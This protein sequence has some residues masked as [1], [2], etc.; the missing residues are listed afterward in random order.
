MTGSRSRTSATS[1]YS[2]LMKLSVAELS[3][4]LADRG[5]DPDEL[6]NKQAMA[7][8]LVEL[9]TE[10]AQQESPE[11]QLGSAPSEGGEAAAEPGKQ[12]E[13][14][15]CPGMVGSRRCNKE[16]VPGD[17]VVVYYRFDEGEPSEEY[18]RENSYC[19]GC[20]HALLAAGKVVALRGVVCEP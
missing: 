2:R 13:P 15:R 5:C 12:S 10:E 1:P 7:K 14:L 3:G 4:M 8:R 20:A 17:W 19:S 11:A 16:L 9:L 6:P 18:L